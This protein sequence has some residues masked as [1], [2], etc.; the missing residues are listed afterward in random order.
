MK[1]ISRYYIEFG[2]FVVFGGK[3]YTSLKSVI[4]QFAQESSS[5][6]LHGRFPS[7]STV[8]LL[9]G[10]VTVTSDKIFLDEEN[11]LPP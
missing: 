7:G 8:L 5:F 3:S 4:C 11:F 9:S 6:S 1:S 2:T 10:L